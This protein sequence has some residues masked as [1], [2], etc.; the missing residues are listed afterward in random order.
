MHE[1]GTLVEEE[2][3][4]ERSSL[5]VKV[6]RK[7]FRSRRR[8][9]LVLRQSQLLEVEREINNKTMSDQRN[10]SPRRSS[11]ELTNELSIAT[12]TPL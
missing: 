12:S 3:T 1:I 7:S 9:P 6:Q 8:H 2:K 4:R 11:R 5:K 10:N